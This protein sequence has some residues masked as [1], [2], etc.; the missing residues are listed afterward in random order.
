MWLNKR[1]SFLLTGLKHIYNTAHKPVSSK[2]LS[3]WRCKQ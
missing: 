1:D 3:Q 2:E